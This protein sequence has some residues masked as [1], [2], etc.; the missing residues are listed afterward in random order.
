MQKQNKAN[1]IGI[2]IEGEN[3]ICLQQIRMAYLGTNGMHYFKYS[4][5]KNFNG[6][7]KYPDK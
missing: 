6:E 1:R 4:P 7:T 2:I 3:T 5:E